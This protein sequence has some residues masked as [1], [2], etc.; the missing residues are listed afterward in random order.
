MNVLSLFDGM[1]CGRLALDK[2]GIT[3]NKYYA[4][5]IDK[6]AI[7]VSSTNWPDNI[8][9]GSV[10]NWRIW[11]INW[12]SVDLILAGSPCQ[13]FSFAGMKLAF[14][15]PRSILYFEFERILKHIRRYNPSVKFMLENVKMKKAHCDVITKRLNV[16]PVFINSSLVSAQSRKRYYWA[17]WEINMPDDKGI[18]LLDILEDLQSCPIGLAVRDKSRTLRVGGRNSPFDSKQQ[19]D[20]PFYRMNKNGEPKNNI[21]K[22]GCLTGGA[23]SGGNHSDMDIL[24]INPKQSSGKRTYQ[25]DR[26][27][28]VFGKSPALTASLGGRFNTGLN[29]GIWR[30]YSITEC[31][32]L[33]TVPDGYTQN[34]GVSATQ[35]YKMLGNGW[36]VDAIV[37]NLSSLPQKREVCHLAKGAYITHFN[38][39][40]K[41]EQLIVDAINE[42]SATGKKVMK[43]KVAKKLGITREH[44]SR[45]YSHLF[46]EQAA[47][48]A[49]ENGA[50][51]VTF[52]E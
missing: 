27:Y 46:V 39:T 31:E 6:H 13:G 2:A 3:V 47:N 23:H 38:R 36:T 50:Y 32:R 16:K 37:N 25:Q 44:I 9:L 8:N 24:C 21:N 12:A 15:D 18:W 45:N 34:K 52:N 43:S 7:K 35:C 20:S 22:A 19:W 33:Q 28:S 42:I 49:S 51:A 26:I 1:S 40:S 4:S 48:K 17:N 11:D 30:R 10:T 41:T 14:D 29:D 5:E